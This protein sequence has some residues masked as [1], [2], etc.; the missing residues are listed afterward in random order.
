VIRKGMQI[1]IYFAER[2]IMWKI[3]QMSLCLVAGFAL[4]YI[5]SMA[6]SGHKVAQGMFLLQEM[7]VIHMQEAAMQAYFNE[8]NEVAVW[9]LENCVETLNRLT[10]ERS[11]ADVENPFIMLVPDQFFVLSHARLGLLYKKM[12]EVEKSKY[13]FDQAISLRKRT[14]MKAFDNEENLIE[15]LTELDKKKIW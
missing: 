8:S 7:E 2:A 4:G 10:D 1:N 3:T 9:A 12:G 15:F 14:K 6:N 5:V 13:N 11:P